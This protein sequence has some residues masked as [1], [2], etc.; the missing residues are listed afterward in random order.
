LAGIEDIGLI[1]S[2]TVEGHL[3]QGISG[4]RSCINLIIEDFSSRE[5]TN[6]V[7]NSELKIC[8]VLTEFMSLGWNRKIVLNKFGIKSNQIVLIFED[9]VIF[10]LRYLKILLPQRL[11]TRSEKL[12]YWKNRETGLR[13]ILKYSNLE[14][15]FCLHPDIE[16]QAESLIKGFPKDKIYTIFPRLN[17]IQSK[18]EN[19]NPS[20]V[21]FGS[22]NRYRKKELKKFNK[23]FPLKVFQ[24]SFEK[25]LGAQHL[26]ASDIFLDLYFKN[27]KNWKYLSPVRIWRTIRQGSFIAYFGEQALDHPIN[28]CAIQ[29]DLY[30]N[31]PARIEN[32]TQITKDIRQ[33]IESYDGV[34]KKNND[35]ALTFLVNM[36]KSAEVTDV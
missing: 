3:S 25:G 33:E 27:S 20:L 28:R 11:K 6:Y 1:L 14:G 13:K 10:F 8:L 19:L 17:D 32:F 16:L 31:F 15:I 22:K 29:V 12:I 2:E 23:V 21:S 24:P 30:E 5:F 26:P 9:T 4:E 35:K 7:L 36:N 34:A 18:E